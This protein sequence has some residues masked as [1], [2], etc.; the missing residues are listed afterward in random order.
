MGKMKRIK[1]ISNDLYLAQE[2]IRQTEIAETLKKESFTFQYENVKTPIARI[3]CAFIKEELTKD[4][5]YDRE[6]KL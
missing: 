6:E 1:E 2:F 4:D 5:S 3:M